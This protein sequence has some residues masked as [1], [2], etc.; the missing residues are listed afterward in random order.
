MEICLYQSRQLARQM[1]DKQTINFEWQT[2]FGQALGQAK[3]KKKVNK[4]KGGEWGRRRS[5]DYVNFG[6]S[7][8]R[9]KIRRKGELVTTLVELM[10][11]RMAEQNVKTK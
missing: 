7:G 6:E 1:K 5:T 8:S 4:P 11:F 10:K 9:E 3:P 2:K